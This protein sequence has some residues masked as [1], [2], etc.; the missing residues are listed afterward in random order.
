MLD[1]KNDEQGG[2]D[3]EEGQDNLEITD[4]LVGVREKP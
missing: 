2:E 3:E 4:A 1:D